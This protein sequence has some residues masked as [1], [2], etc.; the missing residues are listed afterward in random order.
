M[1][2][3]TKVFLILTLV[4]MALVGQIVSEL[5]KVT[6]SASTFIW[7]FE[8]YLSGVIRRGPYGL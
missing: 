7:H 1:V 4:A 5:N 3:N 8:L 6:T 2:L